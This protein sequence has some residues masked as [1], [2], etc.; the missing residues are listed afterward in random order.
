MGCNRMDKH[1]SVGGMADESA[2]NK[3]V[4]FFES[5]VAAQIHQRVRA[6]PFLY[7]TQCEGEILSED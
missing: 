1:A 3:R 4:P 7:A 2:H 6:C 5:N